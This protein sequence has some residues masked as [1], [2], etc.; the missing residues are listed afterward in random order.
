M[1][2]LNPDYHLV[3]IV[4]SRTGTYRPST[5]KLDTYLIPKRGE[6]ATLDQL[7]ATKR[8]IA[9]TKSPYAYLF[10]HTTPT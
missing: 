6:P 2:T 5:A 10:Q 8:G 9:Y 4:N 7:H 1:A 3:G